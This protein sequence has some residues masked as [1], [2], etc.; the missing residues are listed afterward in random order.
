MKH[1]PTDAISCGGQLTGRPFPPLESAA[2]LARADS[3]VS[4]L[5]PLELT[6]PHL[7]DSPADLLL[8]RRVLGAL[9]R[10][11]EAGQVL[12]LLAKK[13]QPRLLDVGQ[14]VEIAGDF[15]LIRLVA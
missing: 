10:R 8:E 13:L 7:R 4:S 12:L 14:L 11:Q 1:A 2:T 6:L 9:Y 3:R 15:G 5:L